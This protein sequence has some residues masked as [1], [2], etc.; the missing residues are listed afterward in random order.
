MLGLAGCG[1]PSGVQIV[2]RDGVPQ[3]SRGFFPIGVYHALAGT[4]FGRRFAM[5][6]LRAAGFN[7]VHVWEGQDLATAMADARASGLRAI[8]HHPSDADVARF[9]ADPALYA[10][11]LDEEP[12]AYAAAEQAA[13]RSAFDARAAAIRRIDPRHP[14]MAIDKNAIQPANR[15][16]W[17]AWARAGDISSHFNYP[18]LS[19]VSFATL[20]T[21]RGIPRSVALAV[22]ANAELKPVLVLLQAFAGPR[23]G[24]RMPAPHELRAMAYAALIHGAT[25][26]VFFGYDSF[27]MRDGQVVGIAP[28]VEADYGPTPDYDGD[29]RPNLVAPPELRT[30]G[31][32]LWAAM[33]ALNAELAELAPWILSRTS[34]EAYDVA[35]PG[36]AVRAI[37][38]ERGGRLLLLTVNLA[39]APVEAEIRLPRSGRAARET[40]APL[41][42]RVFHLGG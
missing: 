40:Y 31:E 3:A 19:G 28:R 22:A 14:I 10:W 33:P 16:T 17:L 24:W 37:L 36:G 39:N 5:S 32:A 8:V 30:A 42:V 35:S 9:A 13:R 2:Y 27:V 41:E 29:G 34:R 38:K 21:E 6:E 7:T 26:L 12:S 25:G 15:E 4:H 23:Q 1:A 20:D 11:Y 18:L